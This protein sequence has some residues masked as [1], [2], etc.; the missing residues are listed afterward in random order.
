MAPRFPE[1]YPWSSFYSITQTQQS[2]RFSTL[3]FAQISERCS[4]NAQERYTI[5]SLYFA[6]GSP[7]FF[8]QWY[9]LSVPIPVGLEH[10]QQSVLD[11]ADLGNVLAHDLEVHL[12]NHPLRLSFKRRTPLPV[13]QNMS[14][15]D[16][17]YGQKANIVSGEISCIN[18]KET[19]CFYF[20]YLS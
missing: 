11:F 5:N 3:G 2:I 18:V 12:S 1:R 15:R 20:L 16:M 13:Y 4:A 8:T 17:K 6:E 9:H 19:K 14:A 7:H 10:M